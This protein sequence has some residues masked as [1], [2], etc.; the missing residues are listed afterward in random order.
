[1]K[2]APLTAPGASNSADLPPIA[3]ELAVIER[4][5][6]G[7]R[8]AAATLFEWFADG[9]YRRIILPRL[10]NREL[11]EEIIGQTGSKSEL[12]MKDLP[13]DDPKQRKP[14]IS[15]AREKLGW[16]PKVPLAEGLK[17]TIEYFREIV[18]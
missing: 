4:L 1:M 10:P 17:P 11:A 5:K 13:Q 2:E 15:L 14:N 8:S 12:V 18:L 9:L 16:E 3:E 6:Q 7:D